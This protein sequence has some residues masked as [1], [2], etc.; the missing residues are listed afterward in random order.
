M[1]TRERIAE[2]PHFKMTKMT[3]EDELE[4][5]LHSF[6]RMATMVG[7]PVNQWTTILIPH[8]IGPIQL[9]VD[10]LPIAEAQD[11]IKVKK[12]ILNH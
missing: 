8:L 5:Y 10:T 1:T 9:A 3:P 12:M 2:A 11:Y 7:W 6:E 4:A